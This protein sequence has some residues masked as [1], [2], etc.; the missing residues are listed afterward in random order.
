MGNSHNGSGSESPL[1]LSKGRIVNPGQTAR[2]MLSIGTVFFAASGCGFSMDMLTTPTEGRE[3]QVAGTETERGEDTMPTDFGDTVEPQSETETPTESDTGS[4]PVEP[5]S[6]T[7]THAEEDTGVDTGDCAHGQV[8]PSEVLLIGDSWISLP[9]PRVGQLARQAGVLALDEDYVFRAYAGATIEDI[10]AQYD[11]YVTSSGRTIK[12][13]IMNGGAVDT[14]RTGGA[15]QTVDYVVDV[16]SRFLARPVSA[17][18]PRDVIYALYAEGTAIPG[19][20]EMREPMR[21]A[22]EQSSPVR[23]HFLDLNEVMA[24]HSE[25][26]IDTINPSSAGSDAIA[27][28]IWKLMQDD[29]IAQ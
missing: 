29:C 2:L 14:Y 19:V 11:N 22:C 4:E 5:Q 3:T 9:G 12:V 1:V 7:E 13:V 27:G 10:V 26:V 21:T 17:Q 16:F 24:G 25:Y 15:Q 23:C 28:A 18:T 6:E 8:L 20:P